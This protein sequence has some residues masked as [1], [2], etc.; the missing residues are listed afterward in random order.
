[1]KNVLAVIH[2]PDF[3]GPHNQVL[4]LY[5]PLMELGWKTIVAL[6]DEANIAGERLRDAGIE[7][8]Q[9]PFHRL[10]AKFNPQIQLGYLRGYLPEV[11]EFQR[12][13]ADKN[14][15]LVQVCGLMNQHSAIAAKLRH[16]PVVWQLL[17]TT[18]PRALRFV[19]M[20]IVTRLADV[21]MTTGTK[22]A[23]LHPGA[24]SF[25]N[26]LIEFFP[27]VDTNK[28][29][30][31]I[32]RRTQ[33]RNEL[34]IPDSAV[35]VGTVGNFNKLK[36][37]DLLVNIA[38]VIKSRSPNT[39]FRI[40]GAYTPT[41]AD[42]Y[43]KFVKSRAETLGLMNGN[44]LQFV[45]PGGKVNYYLSALDIFVLTSR[46]EGIPT[47]MLEALATGLP[48][49][50]NDIGS[51]SEIVENGRNGFIVDPPSPENYADSIQYLIN[52]K[53]MRTELG[54]N[55]RKMIVEKFDIHKCAQKHDKA[56]KLALSV[57][58]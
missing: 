25:G 43:E 7:V 14:I 23:H 42:Y 20:P 22:V 6:P 21:I 8:I 45:N 27:P 28:F 10:R 54:D 11:T 49:V 3:G 4:Q 31:D 36:G 13:I 29:I 12:I 19:L 35:L 47:V 51:V 58:S 56:Y 1:M 50:T 17:G 41:H 2:P 52:D 33:A 57:H 24:T 18:A 37:H 44:K 40:F 48:I 34:Q 26:R 46:A 39:Y 53:K 5:I 55:G 16:I 15:S 9:F 32:D 38:N 30:P